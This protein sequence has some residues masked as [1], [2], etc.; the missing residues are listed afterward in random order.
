[1]KLDYMVLVNQLLL[2]LL[3]ALELHLKLLLLGVNVQARKKLSSEKNDNSWHSV[4]R[5]RERNREFWRSVH[6][7]SERNE[8]SGIRFTESMNATILLAIGP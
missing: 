2:G 6:G 5:I 7:I 4:H 3:K 1:M 8:S